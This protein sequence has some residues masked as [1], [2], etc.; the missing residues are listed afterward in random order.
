MLPTTD[1]PLWSTAEIQVHDGLSGPLHE[2]PSFVREWGSRAS[3]RLVFGLEE[4]RD[5]VVAYRSGVDDRVVEI[6][7]RPYADQELASGPVLEAVDES[8]LHLALP[9]PAVSDRQTAELRVVATVG[10]AEYGRHLGALDRSEHPGLYAGTW[11]HWLRAPFPPL[12]PA[13][14]NR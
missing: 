9:P 13:G 1:R 12:A 7:K 5:K 4:L 8:G 3:I 14:V 2:G 10:W 11:V 6:L